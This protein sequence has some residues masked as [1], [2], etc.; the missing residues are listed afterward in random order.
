MNK[1][2]ALIFIV[3]SFILINFSYAQ[4]QSDIRLT[5]DPATSYKCL[6]N[7]CGIASLGNFIHVFWSDYRVQSS[8]EQIFY[9]RSTD[10]GLTWG[11]D[12]QFTNV[13][14][15]A[16]YPSIIAVGSYIHV[17]WFDVRTG[18]P[19]IFYRRSIDNGTNW[20]PDTQLSFGDTTES[21]NPSV[22]IAGPVLH[23]VWHDNRNGNWEIYYRRSPDAGV[24]WEPETRL[25]TNSGNSQF[26]SVCVWG[27]SVHLTWM[28]D[29]DGNKEI[30]YKRSTDEGVSWGQD[31]RLTVDTAESN[32]PSIAVS[33]SAL[34]VV[35]QDVRLGGWEIWG[36][37]SLDG[38]LTWEADTRLT[39]EPS[40]SFYPSV[41]ASG[42]NIHVAWQ[43]VRDNNWEIYYKRSLDAGASWEA[44]M[45]LTN[46]DFNSNTPSIITNG[47]AVDVLW[48]DDRDGNYEIYYKRDPTGN[49]PIGIENISSEIPQS[50]SLSQNYPNPFNP[51]TNIKFQLPGQSFVNIIIFDNLG[52]EISTLVNQELNA[53]TYKVSWTAT[54][55]PSGVYFYKLTAGS[56]SETKK[57]ILLK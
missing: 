19:K 11:P 16:V 52:R 35:W 1:I 5:N 4:F 24:T 6:N 37:R 34:Y 40:N 50:Y 27:T 20:G 3:S 28:D 10:G 2:I 53:G 42:T 12:I 26:A 55:F 51:S 39:S 29:R 49:P 7:T 8:N 45:R 33:Y 48:Q 36:K 44:D 31:T 32:Y 9:K 18:G 46:S 21:R 54:N 43:D 23:V 57:M 17:V 14:S 41:T 15:S 56:Y 38:G 22:V 13:I 47:T 25:T 30:Y